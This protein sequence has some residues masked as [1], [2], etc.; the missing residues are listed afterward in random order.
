V[1]LKRLF[2]Q[3]LAR[4]AARWPALSNKLVA[5]FNPVEST[6]VPWS[7]VK[8]SLEQSKIALVTTAGIHHKG[9]P[10]FDMKDSLGDPSFRIIDPETIAGDYQITHD[11]YDH[12]DADKD[13]NIIFPITRLK[14]MHSMH[15]VGAVAEMHFSFMGHIDGRH[16]E[17]LVNRTAP[18]VA[19]ML[20]DLEVDA[21]LLTPA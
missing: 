20:K 15:C 12:R 14:E 10:P 11:Y 18:Q 16:V 19:R 21:V 13:L 17:T 9:Q 2:H 1:P 4:L 5:S 3:G 8:K 6:T 7:P